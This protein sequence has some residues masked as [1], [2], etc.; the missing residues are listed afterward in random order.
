[1]EL[2]IAPWEAAL[3]EVVQ[4]PTP[5]GSVDLRIPANSQSGQKLRLKER[6]IPGVT[7][8]DLYVILKVVLPPAESEQAKAIYQEMKQKMAFNPRAKLN[9]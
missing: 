8:G 2:P 9:G 6:G 7:P 5:Q 1:M 4:V 3:G